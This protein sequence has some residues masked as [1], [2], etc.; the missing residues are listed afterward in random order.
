MYNL[1][2]FIVMDKIKVYSSSSS[3]FSKGSYEN[4]YTRKEYD[5]IMNSDEHWPGGYVD[6]LGYVAE[7]TVIT[8]SWLSSDSW[9]DSWEEGSYSDPWADSS[10]EDNSG[11]SQG[12]GGNSGNHGNS[13]GGSQ[14]NMGGSQGGTGGGHTSGTG[15]GGGTSDVLNSTDFSGYR[16]DDTAGCLRRCQEMLAKSNCEL[17]GAE[18]A[19]MKY[20]QNGRATIATSQYSEGISYIDNQLKAGHPVIVGVDYKKGHSTG[21]GRAD[22]AADH[23]VII[24]GGNLS[25]GYHYFDPA[26]ASQER[27]TSSSNKFTE[28]GGVLKS[29]TNCTGKTHEYTLTSVRKNK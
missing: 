10:S 28:Q 11:S 7:D 1:N 2:N 13:G 23:F 27:G 14:G 5:D 29:T 21:D 26:T 24:V 4:P 20:D 15:Q 25:S 9:F 3:S 16:N 19:I 6:S 17:S 18:I 22:Q 12:T 8:D